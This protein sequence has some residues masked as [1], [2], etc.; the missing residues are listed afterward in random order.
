MSVI[1]FGTDGWRAL[2][3]QDF[4]TANV[5]LVAQAH[6]QYLKKQSLKKQNNP[7]VVIGYDTRFAGRMFA[8]TA[9]RVMA[10]NGI[11]VFLTN[12]FV[13]TPVLSHA[14]KHLNAG[15][16]VM[17]TASHNPAGYNGYK[18]KG[19]YGGS[20]TP[21]IVL[22]IEAELE[23][24][25]PTPAFDP[26]LHSIQNLEP[27]AAYFADIAKL[28]DLDVLRGFTGTLFHDAMGGA[29]AGYLGR[30]VQ[31]ADL[32]LKV[33][34]VRG[35]ADPMFYGVNPEP[36]VQN[37]EVLMQLMRSEPNLSVAT[38][39]DGDA[40]RVGAV[41]PGGGYFS[42]HQI[43]CVLLDHLYRKGLRGRVVKTVSTTQ[44]IDRMAAGRGLEVL[45]TPIGFKY[46]TDAMLE[47]NV[48]MGGEES[49]G[50]GVQGHIPERDGLLNSLLLLEAVAAS[51]KGLNEIFADLERESDTLHAYDR[52]D[53][54]LT[55]PISKADLDHKLEGLK[56]FAG[57][58]IQ[59]RSSKDGVKLSLDDNAWVL[60]RASGTEPVLRLYSEALNAGVVAGILKEAQGLFRV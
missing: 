7:R 49:G 19:D 45:E 43:F 46:I 20:A 26:A 27:D 3:A 28:L 39:T 60:F 52:V 59:S 47:G 14:V 6:A 54:K 31:F 17:I 11:E 2:I 41:L 30:F 18:I 56:E 15:G 12:N 8:E 40:D 22:A 10:A 32:K 21:A 38:V 33:I 25:E 24:L 35:V 48:L 53:L 44:M 58:K 16:G 55:Q 29:G 13:P 9:A 1:K 23:Q 42:S 5:A 37:L 57:H 36:I 50:L 51:G 4:T 34:N